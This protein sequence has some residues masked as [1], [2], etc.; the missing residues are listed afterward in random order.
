MLF[1]KDSLGCVIEWYC[2]VGCGN[3]E[4]KPQFS[5]SWDAA[6]L[7]SFLLELGIKCSRDSVSCVDS[8]VY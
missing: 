7:S 3:Q 6:F 5:R 4:N 2:P 8:D 1:E